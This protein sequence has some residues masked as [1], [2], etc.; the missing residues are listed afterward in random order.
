MTEMVL[1]QHVGVLNGILAPNKDKWHIALNPRHGG[2]R[3]I[4]SLYLDSDHATLV[5]NLL[6]KPSILSYHFAN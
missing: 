6:D 2:R 4:V 5:N 1:Q 3:F